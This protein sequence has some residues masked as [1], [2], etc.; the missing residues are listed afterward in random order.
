M[1]RLNTVRLYQAAKV[2]YGNRDNR[3]VV[4]LYRYDASPKAHSESCVDVVTDDFASPMPVAV[5]TR[6]EKTIP[7]SLAV[8][9][10]K[11]LLKGRYG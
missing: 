6:N 7:L 1:L 9:R 11:T 2:R 4:R 5:S 8:D 3:I 10:C